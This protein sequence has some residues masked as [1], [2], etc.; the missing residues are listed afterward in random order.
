MIEA[1][2]TGDKVS[3]RLLGTNRN[4][5]APWRSVAVFTANN[6]R[7]SSDMRRRLLWIR[8]NT[9][10]ERPAEQTGWTI[11][12]LPSYMLEHRS[13]LLSAALTIWRAWYVA[14]KPEAPLLGRSAFTAWACVRHALMHAGLPDPWAD[15]A[16][17]IA[18]VETETLRAV[19][20]AWP[21]GVSMTVTR[22]LDE[23]PYGYPELRSALLSAVPNARDRQA[24]TAVGR[25]LASVRDRPLDGLTIAARL[26]RNKVNEYI[27]QAVAGA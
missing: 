8:L 23:G 26:N 9:P 6:A 16:P 10:A 1:M 22:A 19:L 4:V 25:W 12:D 2:L 7:I 24:S 27:V 14:G 21:K 13:R 3:D 17:E 15:L 11:A 18:D 5:N 20:C